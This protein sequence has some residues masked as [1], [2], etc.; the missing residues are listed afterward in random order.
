MLWV[1]PDNRMASYVFEFD[2]LNLRVRTR[3]SPPGTIKMEDVRVKLGWSE[4]LA[5]AAAGRGGHRR[6][7]ATPVAAKIAGTP[8]TR[9]VHLY[10]GR[11]SSSAPGRLSRTATSSRTPVVAHLNGS[12]VARTQVRVGPTDRVD[13]LRRPPGAR[14]AAPGAGR[15]ERRGRQAANRGPGRR[16]AAGRPRR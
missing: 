14:N 9:H 11:A 12:A 1:E 16:H 7:S 10:D 5:A 15:P 2:P 4:R 6:R 13:A 8:D 3:P